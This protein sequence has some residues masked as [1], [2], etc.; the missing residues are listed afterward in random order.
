MKTVTRY[1]ALD[2]TLFETENECRAHERANAYL[3]LVGLTAEQITEALAGNDPELAE[4]IETIG[5]RCRD[6]RIAAGNLKRKPKAD[7]SPAHEHTNSNSAEN[8]SPAE[9]AEPIIPTPPIGSAPPDLPAED[10]M[11]AYLRRSA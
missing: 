5:L 11:P 7:R 10:D 6:N 4:A 9:G 8:P 1:L 3:A 2:G